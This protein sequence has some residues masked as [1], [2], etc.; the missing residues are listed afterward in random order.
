M[1]YFKLYASLCVSLISYAYNQVFTLGT[2]VLY[3]TACCLTL[4]LYRIF[5]AAHPSSV[6]V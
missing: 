6:L 4:L 1:V 5:C 2:P 3:L